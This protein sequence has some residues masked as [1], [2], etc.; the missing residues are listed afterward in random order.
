MWL[1]GSNDENRFAQ[2]TYKFSVSL[3]NESQEDILGYTAILFLLA[4]TLYHSTVTV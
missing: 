4:V 1:V 3:V 2:N